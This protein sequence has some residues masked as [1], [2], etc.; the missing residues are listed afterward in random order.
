MAT[1]TRKPTS[2]AEQRA[3]LKLS[4]FEVKD[5]LMA[6]AAETEREG[7]FPMLN[8]GRG[9]PNW[10]CTTPREAFG[11]L[12]RFAIEETR[13]DMS[14]PD[15][16]RMP[17][18][19]GSGAAVCRVPG[20]EPDR[21][22]RQ[23]A[24]GVLRL[25]REDAE[26]RSRHVRA[27]AGGRHHRRHV[28]GAGPDAALHRAHRPRVPDAGD[29]RREAPGRAIRPVRGRG[30][31]RRH[32]LHLQLP[33]VQRP[34]PSRGHHRPGRSDVPA[35]H[36]DPAPR[37]LQVQGREHR[38][39]QGA[40]SRRHALLAVRGRGDRQAGG[41]A[42]QGVLPRQPEQSAVLRDASQLDAAAG[43][44]REEPPPQPDDRH[45]RRV[46]HLRPG[47]PVADGRAPAADHRGLLVLEALRVHRLAPRGRGDPP[48]QHLR[49]DDREAAR[50]G[51]GRRSTT[52]T[53]ASR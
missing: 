40:A 48:G 15:A 44:A 18:K 43:Q 17:E 27:R 50:Q 21:A 9:N 31:H 3:L 51:R 13:R 4:P 53:A 25:R 45:R 20:R 24:P 11:T 35:L 36:R 5:K 16:G 38:R 42:D 7:Q 30:R 1:K 37:S 47:L 49:Q 29:V 22:G 26:A 10:L 32:V 23:A 8:A 28:P 2:R 46:R 12:L 39:G 52:G 19:A 33:D 6:L 41:Q 14:I 34:A